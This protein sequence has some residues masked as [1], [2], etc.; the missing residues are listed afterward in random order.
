MK[1]ELSSKQFR[2]LLDLVYI[3]NWVLN[4]ARGNDRIPDF[5]NVESYIFS[6][7]PKFDMSSLCE[8]SDGEVIPSRAFSEGGIHEAIMDYEDSVFFDILADEL[9][10]RDC[11]T[12][13]IAYDELPLR[14]ECYLNEFLENG[15]TNVSVDIPL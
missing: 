1:I 10:G 4:S 7:C 8:L 11:D 5:D 6:Q 14:R 13:T 9:S 15:I 3:G 2:R 12:G